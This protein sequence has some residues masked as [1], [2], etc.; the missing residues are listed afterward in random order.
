MKKP[1][2]LKVFGGYAIIILAISVLIV[3]LSFSTIRSHY[4][5]TLA[6]EM[7]YLGRAL[8]VNILSF[9]ESGRTQ[10]LDAFLKKLGK[11]IHARVTVID[12]QGVVL[13]DS[14]KNPGQMENHRYRPEV[15]EALEGKIGKSLRYSVT[16][17]E[18]MLYVGLP[19]EKDAR[20]LGVL[21]L[22]LFMKNIDVLL[23]SLMTTIGRAVLIM[24][25]GAL[26][27]ALLFSLQ[28]TRPIKKLTGAARQVAAGNFGTRVAIRHKDEFK[29]LGDA[30]NM[31]T[32][33][34]NQLFAEV[35][36][37]KEG[38]AHIIAS[39][40]EGLV[41]LDKDGRLALANDS[42]KELIAEH[43][44]E[45][46]F[47]WEVIRKPD[48]Q[49]FIGRAMSSREPVT[50]EVRLDDRYFLCTAGSLGPQGGIIITFHDLTNLKKVETMKKDFIVNASHELRTPLSAIMGA[51]ETLDENATSINK[52][53]LDILKR[54]A[55]KLQNIVVD[56]LKMAELEDKGYSLDLRDVNVRQVA[57]NVLQIYAPRVK[58]KGLESLLDA[59]AS[60]P[61]L[62][63]D[64]YQLE[65]MLINLVDNA[66]KYTEK[67]RIQ[68]TIRAEKKEFIVEVKDTGPGIPP[69]HVPR[70]FERFY[71]V[72]KSRSRK[73][74]G[75]GLGL[76]IVKHIVQLH[77]GTIT[78]AS[79]AGQG[80]A[81]TVRLPSKSQSSRSL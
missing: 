34:V 3:T 61:L 17:E 44:P 49:E 67:G 23:H 64:P 18:K 15:T 68:I 1:I 38:L 28:I 72:D 7:E 41:V 74:G 63:A 50:E 71:V 52:V 43:R 56:L 53:A 27:L 2:F 30:F 32:D 66:V 14:E 46:K 8:N 35:S 11:D 81:F 10:D 51:M 9:V 80:T 40:R 5:E 47:Y 13:A 42:F 25:V 20:I 73:L 77:G 54:H 59:P 55:E 31:M 65:Q 60:L 76:S 21:R 22:S 24:A 19:L 79:E 57:E 69:E 4:E 39:I 62:K 70:I 6:Q 16:V 58:N 33:Q 48:I 36:R 45:E 78:V 26:L 37:Q 75:T 29:E 12:P